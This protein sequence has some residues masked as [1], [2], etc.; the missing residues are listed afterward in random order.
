M[1]I[2]LR[3]LRLITVQC[4]KT[5]TCLTTPLSFVALTSKASSAMKCS[6]SFSFLTLILSL[7]SF[8]FVCSVFTIVEMLDGRDQLP[9][10]PHADAVW[11]EKSV[12]DLECQWRGQFEVLHCETDGGGALAD[13]ADVRRHGEELGKARARILEA[14]ELRQTIVRQ[15][16]N[17]S[18]TA[19]LED[20]QKISRKGKPSLASGQARWGASGA[21]S[22]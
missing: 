8:L 16:R 12:E 19:A 1:R 7:F 15:L 21:D 22:C 5:R 14:E 13:H 2:R 3:L 9:F 10:G 20:I 18:Q 11:W 6:Q 17:R 4:T